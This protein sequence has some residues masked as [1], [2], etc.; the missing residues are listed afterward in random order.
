MNRN[1]GKIIC[2]AGAT[3]R[4][5]PV[6]ILTCLFFFISQELHI[7]GA[8]AEPLMF[9]PYA[10]AIVLSINQLTVVSGFRVAYYASFL[11][12]I[13]LA[14][15]DLLKFLSTSG[16]MAC[17]L[18]A[19]F[20][21]LLSG[22]SRGN[23]E[24]ARYFSSMVTNI[25]FSLL[26]TVVVCIVAAIIFNTIS[27]IFN[28]WTGWSR[29]IPEFIFSVILPL[30]FCMFHYRTESDDC[31]W[32]MSRIAEIAVKFIICPAIIIYTAILYIYLIEITFTAELPKGGVAAMIIA[33]Y[34]IALAA[35]LLYSSTDSN[36]F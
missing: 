8:G 20:M 4:N 1:I 33:F 5:F 32:S 17:M 31:Q 22:R 26:L 35:K 18:L 2:T 27:F 36:N 3:C 30:T 25:A 21:V 11:V 23:R 7:G 24:I 15:T 10:F 16:Y 13:P 9:L 12:T 19:I 34:A 29:H 14:V 28:I 6:E